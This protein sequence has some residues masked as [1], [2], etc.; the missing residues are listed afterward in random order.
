MNTADSVFICFHASSQNCEKWLLALSSLSVRSSVRLS[1]HPHGKTRLPLDRLH[2][3]VIYVPVFKTAIIHGYLHL[4]CSQYTSRK[5]WQGT[6]HHPNISLEGLRKTSTE[7]PAIGMRLSRMSQ[8]MKQVALTDLL[9]C[10]V[11]SFI[12]NVVFLLCYAGFHCF[13]VLQYRY[14]AF[15][16]W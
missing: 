5:T 7:E 6:K 10:D 3:N 12:V 1:V 8:H 9:D 15:S 16:S 4:Q 11:R 13:W 2:R 14:P